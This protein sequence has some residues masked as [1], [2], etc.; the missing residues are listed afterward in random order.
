ML[1]EPDLRYKFKAPTVY[2]LDAQEAHLGEILNTSDKH[3][4]GSAGQLGPVPPFTG[5]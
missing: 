4:Y 5:F 2:K 1:D 3:L